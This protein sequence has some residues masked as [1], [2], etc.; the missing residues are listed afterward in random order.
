METMRDYVVR[1]AAEEK[2]YR[3]VSDETEVGYEWLCK[4]AR[5]EIP[6]PGADRIE[7]LFY[8]YKRL[9]KRRRA[10]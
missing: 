4:L 2:R 1:R 6:N 3:E 9:E 8:Y 5:D 7:R 10:A